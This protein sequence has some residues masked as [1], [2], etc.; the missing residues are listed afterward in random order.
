MGRINGLFYAAF[1]ALVGGALQCATQSTTFILVARVVTGLG[2]GALTGI[3]PV[4][5]AEV[6]SAS[7]RGGFLG[8]VFIANYL[9]I[10]VAYWI[11]F[12]LSFVGDDGEP[13]RWL[14]LLGFQC[15]PALMLLAGI[16]ML[17]DSPR[18][19]VSAGRLDEAR[20]ILVHV[21]GGVVTKRVEQEFTEICA[22][23]QG[24]KKSSPVE[25]AKILLG[26][27][28]TGEQHLARRAWLCLWLQI[29]ASWTGITVSCECALRLFQV[30]QS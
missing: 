3:T 21:R 4:L 27:S 19:L 18:Y 23:A 14:F 28:G 1:F 9:G 20:E 15:I 12:G 29:M 6:S 5:V 2:T 11:S 22:V 13:I 7:H 16:K 25:F 17:P 8:Y 30:S 24:T 26:R 10:S